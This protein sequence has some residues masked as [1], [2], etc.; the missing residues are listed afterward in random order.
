MVIDTSNIDLSFNV[1]AWWSED[2]YNLHSVQGELS[3]RRVDI[4]GREMDKPH[5]PRAG[6]SG[7][8]GEFA[9]WSGPMLTDNSN[10]YSVTIGWTPE[11]IPK[12]ILRDLSGTADPS[13][14]FTLDM[15][16]TPTPNDYPITIHIG[17]VLEQT[18]NNKSFWDTT[19]TPDLSLN[20]YNQFIS[21]NNP[22]NTLYVLSGNTLNIPANILQEY[23]LEKDLFDASLNKGLFG[24]EIYSYNKHDISGNFFWKLTDKVY[25]KRYAPLDGDLDSL[26]HDHEDKRDYPFESRIQK[27]VHFSEAE[28][29][30]SETLTG[31]H[32][33]RDLS[34]ELIIDHYKSGVHIDTS[35]NSLRFPYS[36]QIRYDL[37]ITLSGNNVIKKDVTNNDVPIGRSEYWKEM[38]L[39]AKA[40]KNM[41]FDGEDTYGWDASGRDFFRI[42]R[43]KKYDGDANGEYIDA[44]CIFIPYPMYFKEEL[45]SGNVD[46]DNE[47]QSMKYPGEDGHISYKLTSWSPY[48]TNT[49]T[50]DFYHDNVIN[51]RPKPP[52]FKIIGPI[53]GTLD[54]DIILEWSAGRVCDH[55][56]MAAK[57]G[58]GQ[59]RGTDYDAGR[60]HHR[61]LTY[62]TNE[63]HSLPF[64]N[65]DLADKYIK[66]TL[67][68]NMG[69]R[70][71]EYTS[72]NSDTNVLDQDGNQIIINGKIKSYGKTIIK[73]IS[74][75]TNGKIRICLNIPA[76]HNV[77]TVHSQ[78]PFYSESY[79]DDIFIDPDG[80]WRCT[81]RSAKQISMERERS[82]QNTLTKKQ[83]F[84][85]AARGLIGCRKRR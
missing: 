48:F 61:T 57:T 2:R 1:Y 38:T 26:Q 63:F 37:S 12:Y 55:L 69:M 65:E 58:K 46:E 6:E 85:R 45:L 56:N 64:I 71:P 82:K 73:D 24:F 62:T 80:D 23:P 3:W 31:T 20:N 76:G 52:I 84:A 81:I 9:F 42:D 51:N 75:N 36:D 13:G 74:G 11:K 35:N 54:A 21:Q 30:E 33:I 32:Y 49:G 10:P 39:N 4:S 78:E 25:N 77:F 14:R 34:S 43:I 53:Y 70:S 47:L 29:W 7:I 68:S 8:S 79:T 72:F 17:D 59:L 22:F 83:L 66:Y 27:N 50:E 18:G 40:L 67:T 16:I 44:S 60:A 19:Q 5:L 28:E 15:N 41:D